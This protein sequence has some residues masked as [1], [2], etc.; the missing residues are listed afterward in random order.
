MINYA[1]KIKKFR[2]LKHEMS[3]N[4]TCWAPFQ[5]IHVDK[6]G[7]FRSCPFSPHIGK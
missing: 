5:A 1:E 2:S 4:V 6:G 7:Y 3:K